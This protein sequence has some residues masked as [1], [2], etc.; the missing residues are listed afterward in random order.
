VIGARVKAAPALV[1]PQIPSATT[2]KIDQLVTFIHV[3][4]DDVAVFAPAA[5]DPTV[6]TEPFVAITVYAVPGTAD[7]TASLIPAGSVPAWYQAS[8]APSGTT[9]IPPAPV[10]AAVIEPTTVPATVLPATGVA[11]PAGAAVVSTPV[12]IAVPVVGVEVGRSDWQT[13]LEYAE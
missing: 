11:A 13:V 2:G 10:A 3:T 12:H 6:P 9:V 4:A 8:G 1:V 7:G 5:I